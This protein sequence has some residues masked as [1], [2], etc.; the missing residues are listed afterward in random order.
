MIY[1]QSIPLPGSREGLRDATLEGSA[2]W[3]STEVTL[4]NPAPT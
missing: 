2:G 1:R 4:Y 3:N